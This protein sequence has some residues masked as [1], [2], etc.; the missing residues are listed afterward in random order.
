MVVIGA[1]GSGSF[2]LAH[3]ARFLKGHEINLPIKVFDG[4]TY[5]HSGNLLRA[6]IVAAADMDRNKAEV[7]CHRL[8]LIYGLNVFDPHKEYFTTDCHYLPKSL[9]VSCVDSLSFRKDLARKIDGAPPAF[10]CDLGNGLDYGQALL[11]WNE[12]T[13][14]HQQWPNFWN[15]EDDP[16]PPCTHAPFDIQGP[17]VNPMAAMAAMMLIKPILLNQNLT[18]KAAF[19]GSFGLRFHSV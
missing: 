15:Q 14:P 11:G 4:D 17:L 18:H 2:F 10:W 1:G 13:W 9:V 6:P 12:T 5:Q 16:A 19:F 8:N 3:L 7:L